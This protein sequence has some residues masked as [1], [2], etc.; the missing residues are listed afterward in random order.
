M[1]SFGP[2][3]GFSLFSAARSFLVI[4]VTCLGV[5]PLAS[6]TFRRRPA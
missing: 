5:R 6:L 2:Y 3:K 4:S 1:C